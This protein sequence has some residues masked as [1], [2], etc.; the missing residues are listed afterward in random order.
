MKGAAEAEAEAAQGSLLGSHDPKYISLVY[1]V[2]SVEKIIK[3]NDNYIRRN[4]LV[5][6]APFCF[7]IATL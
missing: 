5:F 3:H 7:R 1:N 6:L 2:K 4:I